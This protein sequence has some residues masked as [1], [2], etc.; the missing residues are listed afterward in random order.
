MLYSIEIYEQVI[1]KV[2]DLYMVLIY[3]SL[4][5]PFFNNNILCNFIIVIYLCILVLISVLI[6]LSIKPSDSGGIAMLI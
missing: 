6:Y 1:N 4:L 2:K 3:S 5:I